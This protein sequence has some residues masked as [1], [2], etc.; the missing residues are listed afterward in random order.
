MSEENRYQH[1]KKFLKFNDDISHQKTSKLK[2]DILCFQIL[3][4]DL[5]SYIFK[6]YVGIKI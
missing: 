1:S 4:P 5:V 3:Y 6:K 2:L